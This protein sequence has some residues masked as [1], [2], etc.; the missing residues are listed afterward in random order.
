MATIN[1]VCRL[2][3]VSKATVSRVIN[4]S[5]QV[6]QKTRDAVH[7][8]M[9]ELGYQPN[10]LAQALATNTSNSIGLIL[11]H[12]YSHYFGTL[13]RQAAQ[14]IQQANKRLYVMDSHNGEDGELDAIRSL[15]T[16]RCDA[17]II[18]SRQLS[19][20]KLLELQNEIK[21]PIVVLNRSLSAK[22]LHSLGF[23]QR[24]VATIAV[25]HLID[26]GH[27]HIA[28]ITN[29]LTSDTGRDRLNAYKTCLHNNGLSFNPQLVMEGESDMDTGYKAVTQWIKDKSTFSAIFASN[30]DMALGAIRALH[31]NGIKVPDD[32]SVVGIDNE[33]AASYSIPSLSTVS[34]PIVQ[35]THEAVSIALQL[36]NKVALTPSHNDFTGELITRE[37]TAAL[38]N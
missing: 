38:A 9:K 13:L 1:D 30:D 27:Q 36:A 22:G 6:K 20:A 10:V 34:L 35:L 21:T 17:I 25:Q 18:Y 5:E 2:A 16:Q 19:E 26:L 24:Q 15:S 33:P 32:V 3:G 4:G 14:D 31:D 23:N 7:D 37:S 12:F 8:A 29:P 28:C 11:P